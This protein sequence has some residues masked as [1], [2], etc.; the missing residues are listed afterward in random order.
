M[1]DVAAISWLRR[2][3][4]RWMS[5]RLSERAGRYLPD[6][7]CGFRLIHLETWTALPLKTDHFEVESET[8]MA[9]LAAGC[10]VEFVPISV[11]RRRS[12]H[13]H[14][15]ADTLRWWKWWRKL[16]Q[17]S[18]QLAI[19]VRLRAEDGHDGEV[20]GGTIADG[21]AGLCE[22]SLVASAESW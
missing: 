9:F 20:D 22:S 17:P 4:N 14:P 10:R 8:L 1:H 2:R 21:R 5:R 18:P 19:A 11:I 7:Q 3:V 12:S 13:I 6:T 16:Q 15:L